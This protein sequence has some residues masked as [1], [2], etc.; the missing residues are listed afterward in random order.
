LRLGCDRGAFRGDVGFCRVHVF[1]FRSEGADLL[2]SPV[3]ERAG[4]LRTKGT[5]Q[6][7]RRRAAEH[8]AKEC[9]ETQTTGCAKRIRE[10]ICLVARGC[11][12]QPEA[13]TLTG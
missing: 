5:R 3:P 9:H 10:R 1:A 11:A 6:R 7:P 2:S 12:E 8:V 13:R 4:P